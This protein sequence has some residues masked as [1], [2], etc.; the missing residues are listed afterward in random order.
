MYALKPLFLLLLF[1]SLS[2]QAS[3]KP[4][5]QKM[6][7]ARVSLESAY[8]DTSELDGGDAS[9]QVSKNR[10]Q[11]NNKI[12]GLSYTNWKFSW[13][14]VGDLDFGDGVHAPIEQ[15]HSIQVNANLPYPINEEWFL[16]TSVALKSTFEKEKSDS[17]GVNVFA[18]ASYKMSE[19]H[20]FELGAFA[21]YHPTATLALPVISYSY[22]AM[23]EDGFKLILGFPRS[24]LGYNLTPK[25]L[26]RS[27][28]IF[29]QSLIRL[30]DASTISL[31]GYIE[32]KDYMSN[33]GMSYEMGEHFEVQGDLLYG[34]K[35]EF[36]I[37]DAAANELSTYDVANGLGAMLK[38]MYRF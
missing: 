29:S 38:V 11:I 15:M 10:L 2:L 21:N 25:L 35:R 37:Y 28:F 32:A 6:I 22:R 16:L 18:F 27:G 3:Q 26:F 33:V 20:R 24:Y 34:L 4:P 23:A 5:L 14:D 30:A 1:A 17:Y 8:L 36:I 19:E 31:S 9:V 7:E 12:A 13:H